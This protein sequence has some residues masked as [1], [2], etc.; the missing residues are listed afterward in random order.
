VKASIFLFI[1]ASFSDDVSEVYDD[2]HLG[3][4]EDAQEKLR[5]ISAC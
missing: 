1:R 5:N 2:E 3:A 4:D